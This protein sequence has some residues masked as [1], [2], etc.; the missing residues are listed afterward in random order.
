MNFINVEIDD[1]DRSL[2]LPDGQRI[3][4]GEGSG[5]AGNLPAGKYIW[6][7]RP[8]HFSHS[9]DGR[10]FRTML[11]VIQ[12]TGSRSFGSFTLGGAHMVAELEA[13][14]G[15]LGERDITLAIAMDRTVFF[16]PDSDVSLC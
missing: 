13:H 10:T 3:A 6:G 12:P 16:D 14:A 11:E 8:E 4:L 5:T 7:V 2:C 1:T 9:S 15:E